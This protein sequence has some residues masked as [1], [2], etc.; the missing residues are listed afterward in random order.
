MH[1][2]KVLAL[3]QDDNTI[4]HHLTLGLPIFFTTLFSCMTIGFPPL[5]CECA[6]MLVLLLLVV[7]LVG[8]AREVPLMLNGLPLPIPTLIEKGRE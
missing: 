1:L 7:E 3:W 4:S 5:P 8:G 2:V 6:G